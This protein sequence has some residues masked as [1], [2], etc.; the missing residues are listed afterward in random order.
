[1]TKTT[2]SPK[3]QVVIPKAVRDRLNLKAGTQV[4]IDVQGETLVL[5]RL[6]SN[7][8]DWHT[9]RGMFRQ[10]PNLLEDLTAEHATEINRDNDRIKGR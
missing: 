2:I 6:V 4:S 8:P 9:M 1:M 3:G 7:F 10:G 5:K